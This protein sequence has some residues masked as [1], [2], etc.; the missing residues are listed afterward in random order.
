MARPP[1]WAS[2]ACTDIS[3]DR[4]AASSVGAF[5]APSAVSPGLDGAGTGLQVSLLTLTQSCTHGSAH[6]LQCSARSSACGIGL[7]MA[8][9]AADDMVACMADRPAEQCMRQSLWHCMPNCVRLRRS[10]RHCGHCGVIEP[11]CCPQARAYVACPP[12]SDRREAAE[13][14]RSRQAPQC[15]SLWC[16]GRWWCCNPRCPCSRTSLGVHAEFMQ[17]SW[18]D[19]WEFCKV[20][21]MLRGTCGHQPVPQPQTGLLLQS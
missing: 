16:S 20:L 1:P 9:H 13:L 7:S 21:C 14:V 2:S 3:Y 11:V 17:S 18:G 5:T 6:S 8:A 4:A 10:H 15:T 12:S 19:L